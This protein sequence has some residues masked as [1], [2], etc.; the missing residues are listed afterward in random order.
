MVT[1]SFQVRHND[2]DFAVVYDTDDGL[3][4]LKYQL[5]SLTSVPPDEQKIIGADDDRVVSD[6]SDL[7]AVSEKLRLVSISDDQPEQAAGNDE[8]LKS[9]EELARM[10][11]AE[12][13]ALMYQQ[14]A[15]REDNGAFEGR[16][17]PYISQV[18]MYE[19]PI[20]QEAARK[21]VSVEQLEEKAL[22]SLAKEGNFTPSK[23]QQDHAFLLQ[24]LFWF[25]QS[26]SWVNQP[27]CDSCGQKTV[28]LGMDAALPPE[29]LHGGS[30][31]EIYRCTS[32]PT[33]T[34]FPRYND[35]LKLVETRRGR[36]G[37]WAN[38]FT[39]YCRTFGFESR[40]ILDF[41]DH[42][43]TECFSESLGRW[44][45]LDPCEGVYDKPLLYES[46]WS[47]KLNYVIAIGKDGVCD[48][49][50]RYTRKWH[51]VL[52]RRNIISE[53]ALSSVLAN[54]TKECR[55][56]YTS[57]VRSALEDRDEK[58][59]QELERDLRS[60]DDAST[61]LPGRRS[62]DKEWRKSRMEDG[63]DES[64]SLTG[65]SCPLRQCVDEHVTKI[66][67][68]FLPILAQ[69]V[70]EGFPKSRAVEV[71]EIL[72][73]LLINLKKSPFKTRRVS[74]DSVPNINQ[75]VVRQLLPS[76]TELLSAL[77]LSSKADTDGRVEISL[78][79]PAV[80]TSLALPVTFHALDITI[81]NLKSCE[82]FV[83]DSL[84]LPLLKLN[85]IH[86][87]VVRASGEEIPFGIATSAFDGTRVSKWEEPNGAKGC[88]I[89][90]KVSD[91]QMHELVAYELMSANDAPERD[92]MDWVVERS[93]DGGS[94][95]HL[96]DKRTSQ[97][98]DSRFQC[99]TFKVSSEGFL[100]NAF[101]FR[102]LRVRDIQS[103]SRLQL[104]SI[105]LYSRSS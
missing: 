50:K 94:S 33:V 56:G 4:V 101:R 95:W 88:W 64:L 98:F 42:V 63:S 51:E 55:R 104:G 54:I 82:N 76:F 39:L 43:W 91:N 40:L 34:R 73:G 15:V 23:K 102:F 35:P 77:S 25:K 1:R 45:H 11:Q 21:T 31:V 48:V 65:S 93:N 89:V 81:R 53:P 59:R 28:S 103:N 10:L 37:E 14:F 61:S 96:I 26:F 71:L 57:Q 38:C 69:L 2:S 12:E 75:S 5:F 16:V 72:K 105:D 60:T 44:M 49:T 78:A 19:D 22:V 52:S 6:D 47:K 83:K 36:C 7:A 13:E 99:R 100:S 9:D 66:Y 29:L 41:T 32:C 46:G 80:K 24:L 8:L 74:V 20:R 85:R 92:P 86:S 27:P 17:R 62:G 79:G 58:E 30:R 18:L 84:C 70:D 87:G 3:E 90:Y 68:G 97:L 67:N